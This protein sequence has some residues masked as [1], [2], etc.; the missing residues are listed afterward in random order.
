MASIYSENSQEIIDLAAYA[1]N[2]YKVYKEDN[3][4]FSETK[5]I[6]LSQEQRLSEIAAML[7]GST[8]TDEALNNARALLKK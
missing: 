2:H 6:Q 8:I 4:L 7:S 5:M 3:D 1:S